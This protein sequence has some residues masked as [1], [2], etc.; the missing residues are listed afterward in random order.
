MKRYTRIPND[1]CYAVFEED[2]VFKIGMY[3]VNQFTFDNPKPYHVI[4]KEFESR[5]FA[6]WVCEILS[7]E[8]QDGY[9]EGQASCY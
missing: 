7:E 3:S 9:S 1:D 8:F 4:D 2:G 6:E 5:S